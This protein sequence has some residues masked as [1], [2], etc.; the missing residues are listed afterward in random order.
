MRYVQNK[1]RLM[2]KQRR[3]FGVLRPAAPSA[4]RKEFPAVSGLYRWR[5]PSTAEGLTMY[6]QRVIASRRAVIGTPIG[7]MGDPEPPPPGPPN[8]P[9]EPTIPDPPPPQ[10]LV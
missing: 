2:I 4:R 6:P 5:Y 9:G 3:R 7:P 10:P 1:G 8:E